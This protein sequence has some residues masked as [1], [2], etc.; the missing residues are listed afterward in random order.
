[1]IKLHKQFI[2]RIENLNEL[3]EKVYKG[4]KHVYF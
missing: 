3:F 1:M 2:E 4:I